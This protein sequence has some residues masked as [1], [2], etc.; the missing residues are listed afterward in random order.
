S[1]DAIAYVHDGMHIYA[2]RAYLKLFGYRCPDDL[3]GTPM[4]DLIA[5]GD[6]AGFKDFLRNYRSETDSA[7]FQCSGINTS[8]ESFDAKI[9]FS[10]AMYDGEPCV[11]VV[12]RTDSDNA[13]LEQKLKAISSQ[14]LATGLFNRQRFLELLSAA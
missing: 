1:I 10:P 8:D 11:Q 9:S 7:D 14:D 3:E 12:I 4:T 6:Q 13:E 5:P 2:N